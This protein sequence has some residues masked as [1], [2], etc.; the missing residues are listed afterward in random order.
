M[1]PRQERFVQE[2][3]VDLNATQAAIR[4]GYA[5]RGAEVTGHRLLRN[6]KIQ[7]AI[8]A[9]QKRR[10]KRVEITQDFVLQG[11]L[12]NFHRS[13]EEMPVLDHQG[14]PIGFFKY[15]GRVA[16]RSLELL[17]KHLGMFREKVEVTGKDGGPL[18]IREGIER[19]LG[20]PKGME[21]ALGLRGQHSQSQPD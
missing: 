16:L 5:K 10:E 13:M 1:T 19:I 21:W 15:D 8:Q 6:P 17:G 14:E 20:D 11:L 2:Y 3:L 4:A 9:A 18:E 12:E 7:C